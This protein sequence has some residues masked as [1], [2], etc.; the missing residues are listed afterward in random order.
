[1]T[2]AST[3]TRATPSRSELAGLA[4]VFLRL[5]LTSFGGPA[6]HI[7]LMREEFVR[8]RRWLDDGAYLDLIG[9]ATLIPGPTSTEV[10]MHVGHR[11]AGWAGLVVAGL[12]FLLPAVLIVGVL[13]WLY[14][15]QGSRPE[16]GAVL[17]GVAPVVIA[18]VAHA[19]ASIGRAVLGTRTGVT[20][21]VLSVG[22][23][24]AGVPEIL[25]LLA[26]GVG[27]LVAREA[28]RR[29]G[30]PAAGI[31]VSLP[32]VTGP[33]AAGT[34]TAPVASAVAALGGVA[35]GTIGATAILAEFMRIGAVLF[36]SGYVLVALLR[37]ELVDGL[38]WINEAQLIDAIAVG[39][40]TPGPLFSTATFIGYLAG[41]PVGAVAATVGIFTPAFVAVAVSI[42]LLERLRRSRRARAFLDGVSAAAVGLL[43]VVAVQ[44]A[45]GS[46]RD[47]IAVVTAVGA[48]AL[49][50]RGVGTGPLVV[51]G[52]AIGLIR[53]AVG[54]PPG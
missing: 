3:L 9:A 15:E 28:V 1:M 36:G 24:A 20:A 23:S 6:A 22:A 48:F 32:A 5:G 8:R 42:P 52:G 12:A 43:A 46:L 33:S 2:W 21:V 18:V 13:A 4:A 25:V 39:L 27:S 40:A 17:V 16:I 19:G 30:V 47:A 53:L 41:G 26:L 31:A 45:L 7:A 35:A 29:A 37:S 49:L 14:V 54:I 44:L 38:G 51:A 34:V 11:R 50:W 10:A